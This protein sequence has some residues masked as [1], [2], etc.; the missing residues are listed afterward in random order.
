MTERLA[1]LC[2]VSGGVNFQKDPQ[3][4]W[5]LIRKILPSRKQMS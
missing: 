4:I 1:R 2:V 5:D 3:H